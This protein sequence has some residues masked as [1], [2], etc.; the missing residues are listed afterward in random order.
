VP[1]SPQFIK[2]YDDSRA[3]HGAAV[4][5]EIT[6]GLC[7]AAAHVSPK[8]FYD[9]LGSSLFEA[10]TAL[11][12]YYP[13][14]TEAAIFNA[15]YAQISAALADS[16]VL[17]SCLIDLG[18]GNCQKASALIPHLLPRQYV[19]VDISVE[20]LR[21]AAGQVQKN[22]PALDIVGLGMDFSNGLVLPPEVQ[23]HD[24]VFFYPGSSIG[25]F[26]PQ[27]A[28]AF[29]QQIANPAQ[30]RAA[31]LLLGID[32]VKSAALLEAAY[33]DALGVTAAFNKNLLRNLN[34]LLGADFDVRQWRHVALFNHQQS[35][36]EMHLQATTELTVNWPGQQRHFNA[37]ERIHTECSYK[38]TLDDM[39][40]LLRQAGFSQV[41]HWTDPDKWFAVFWAAV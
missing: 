16:G 8:Y 6:A 2:L 5:A 31:G 37:G 20:F 15:S 35:R 27:Q 13:T 29:L 12:E 18:A 38:Y 39:T 30:G 11:D 1:A 41:Q 40:G 32:L 14:R 9:P 34:S 21:S 25:N 19:P 24:R 4:V 3:D 33:D 17:N 28:L 26:H 36:I 10:I 7:D 23:A 22:H